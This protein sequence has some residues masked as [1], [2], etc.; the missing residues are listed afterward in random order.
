MYKQL[1]GQMKAQIKNMYILLGV[2]NS[3]QPHIK[4]MK[5]LIL[6]NPIRYCCYLH[7]ACYFAISSP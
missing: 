2:E 7:D 6:K 3:A 1:H 4:K 5:S